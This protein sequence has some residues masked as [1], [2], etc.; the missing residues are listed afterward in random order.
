MYSS[1]LMVLT[2]KGAIDRATNTLHQIASNRTVTNQNRV[3]QN[4]CGNCKI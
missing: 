4:I 2:C 3:N 1:E